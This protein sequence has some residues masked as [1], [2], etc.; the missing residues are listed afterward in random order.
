M[1][2]P[3]SKAQVTAPPPRG[4]IKYP[5]PYTERCVGEAAITAARM[6]DILG[7]EEEGE[8]PFGNDFLFKDMNNKKVRLTKNGRNRPYTHANSLKI[9]QDLLNSGPLL[10]E[11]ERRW[12]YNRE[13]IIIGRY[14]SVC[15]G[16]HRGVGL[17]LA[18]QIWA[19][20]QQDHWLTIWP[21]EP[22]MEADIAYGC[23]EEAY[24]LRTLDNTRTRTFTDVLFTSGYFTAYSVPDRKTLGRMTDYG[25]KTVWERTGCEN[26]QF[27]SIRTHPESLSFLHRHPKLVEAAGHVFDQYKRDW[28]TCS[29]WLAPTY[30]TGL[31]YLMGV[32]ASDPD[33]YYDGDPRSEA[34]VDFK[35]WD[36]ALVFWSLLCSGAAEM[37]EARYAVEEYKDPISGE[38]RATIEEQKNILIKAWLVFVRGKSPEIG[39]VR[40]DYDE[41]D[42][43]GVRTLADWPTVGGIDRGEPKRARQA[44][45]D[46][47]GDDEGDGSAPYRDPTPEEIEQRAAEV[48]ARSVAEQ[49]ARLKA[50]REERAAERRRARSVRADAINDQ[51]VKEGHDP[52]VRLP[53]GVRPGAG[54]KRKVKQTPEE[55]GGGG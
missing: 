20:N 1:P 30:A 23:R 40:L 28:I 25:L 10:P 2:T 36:R 18:A 16:Q 42:E 39:E 7:W 24:V 34:D 32:S 17:R 27:N 49:E 44:E 48:R 52:Q 21:T 15:S 26:N 55:G 22:T 50:E 9:A 38:G 45:A 54:G 13:P 35:H 31:M 5:D 19:G 33:R 6:G 12:Q 11:E 3:K 47:G 41:D 29:K 14:G 51:L 46:D 37:K 53:G 8:E 43:S 4:E